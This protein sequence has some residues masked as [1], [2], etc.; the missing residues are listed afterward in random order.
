[1]R[2]LTYG[3]LLQI[4]LILEQLGE[5]DMAECFGLGFGID[6][7][8][9]SCEKNNTTLTELNAVGMAIA[10]AEINARASCPKGADCRGRVSVIT[11]PT[12]RTVTVN[13]RGR[14][15][16]LCV[17]FATAKFEGDCS[18]LKKVGNG[19]NGEPVTEI[20]AKNYRKFFEKVSRLPDLPKTPTGPCQMYRQQRGRG[21]FYPICAGKCDKGKCKTII[22]ADSKGRIV[23]RCKC[24]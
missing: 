23:A 15:F 14:K 20:K 21:F 7:S 16:K 19:G 24:K 8:K 12:C 6:I 4:Y 11:P 5:C 13:R 1:M 3:E 10:D 18:K 17:C 2:L 22:T 9:G